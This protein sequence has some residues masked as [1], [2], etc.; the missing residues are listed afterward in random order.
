VHPNTEF[1]RGSG[2]A[3]NAGVVVDPSMQSS[4]EGVYAAG[5][6]AEAVDFSTGQHSLNAVQ[7]AAVDQ[8]RTAAFN[9]VGKPVASRGSLMLNVLDTMGLISSSFGKWWGDPNGQSAELVD[10]AGFRFLGLQFEG[11]VMVGATSIGL[12]EHV[13]VLRGL[14]E[15]RVR[16]GSWK[17]ELLRNPLRI[18]DAYIARA[19]A[20]A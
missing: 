8:A 13:G 16:L 1:L 14:I 10:E 6:V 20:V 19:Q 3:C 2:I 5:D 9:M 15:G 11:D 17:E 4:V 7:P 12:T 18:A